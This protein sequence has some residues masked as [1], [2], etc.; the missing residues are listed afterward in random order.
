[1]YSCQVDPQGYLWL[2]TACSVTRYSPSTGQLVTL[3]QS[4][5]LPDDDCNSNALHLD[6]VGRLWVGT[7]R[8]IGVV[9]TTRIPDHIPPCPV[10]LT[11]FRVMGQQCDLLPDMELEDS[12]YDLQFEYGA[13]SMVAP[14][15]VVYRVQLVGLETG[16]SAPTP[17]REQRY[18]N[19]RPGSYTFRASACNWGGT[20]SE[21]LEVRFRVIRNRE[22]LVAKMALRESERRYHLLFEHMTAAFALHQVIC[23]EQGQPTDLLYLEVNP[24]FERLSGVSAASLRGRT[25]SQVFPG[26]AFSWLDML[27]PVALTG[28]PRAFQDYSAGIGQTRQRHRIFSRPR[29]G[30]GGLHRRDRA[31]AG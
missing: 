19:L 14:S 9:D 10:Y 17:Q 2:G 13:V 1:M 8:G 29:T 28:K 27:G 16:W 22:A 15:L 7:A 18:T 30:R 31:Q 25:F 24:A 12:A 4:Q 20:W 11:A 3:D 6:A 26:I 21:P 23:D 5:G